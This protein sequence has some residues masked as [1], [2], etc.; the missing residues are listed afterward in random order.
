M[1]QFN[2]PSGFFWK[3]YKEKN[4]TIIPT[5]KNINKNTFLINCLIESNKKEKKRKK[6]LSIQQTIKKK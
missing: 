5:N 2:L 3:R 4:R 6:I 1:N